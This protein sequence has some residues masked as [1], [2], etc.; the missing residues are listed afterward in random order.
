MNT[1]P[2]ATILV[3]D[4]GL[5]YAKA[6]LFGLDGYI[7]ARSA[8]SYPTQRAPGG[9]VEQEPEAW[10]N[11]IVRATSIV[12]RQ[13][14]ELAGTVAAVTVTGHMH[15]LVCTDAGRALGPALVLG[16]TRA[17][18]ESEALVRELGDASIY[19]VTGAR[20][21]PSMPAAKL[22]WLRRRDPDRFAASTRFFGTKDYIRHL[23]T[24]DTGT[25]PVDAT[26]TSLYDIRSGT[27]SKDLA[28]ACGVNL[29]T[30]PNL[31]RPDKVA[32]PLREEPARA[33][34]LTPGI[35][36]VVG[37]GDDVEVLGCG[38]LQAGEAVEHLGTTGSILAVIPEPF[39]DPS[40]AI[41]LYPHP[42]A[43]LWVVGGSMSSAGAAIDW[44]AHALGFEGRAEASVCLDDVVDADPEGPVFLP[45]IAGERAPTYR[46]N[47]RGAW[48]GL[49]SSSTRTDLMRAAFEGVAFA[50]N[51]LL[52]HVERVAGDQ[53]AIHLSG[54]EIGETW[55]R[56]RADVYGRPLTPHAPTEPTALGAMILAA[57][58]IGAYPNPVTAASDVI[59]RANP[60]EP[61]PRAEGYARAYR[62]HHAWTEAMRP[63]WGALP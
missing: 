8:V 4:V 48:L 51:E 32:G 54:A 43:G 14:A 6:V 44:A 11:A 17:T 55:D 42:I 9:R 25:D 39:G 21:D 47:A 62:R 5:S 22:R 29:A 38:V 34:G 60:I 30:L 27:W 16:D 40:M 19:G 52:A 35:P 28:E 49:S 13:A 31:E 58:A 26:A 33:L 56:L 53:R 50:L 24:G 23:L 1:R 36:V 59:T 10:W 63:L 41:E 61:G 3:L 37:A 2:E 45:S 7:A 46:S 18:A 57:T 12:W 15:A 20:M